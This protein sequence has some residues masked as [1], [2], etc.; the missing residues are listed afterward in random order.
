[1]NER[2]TTTRATALVTSRELKEAFRR[3]SIW[4]ILAVL[5]VGSSAAM[6][7]PDLLDSSDTEYDV[8]IVKAD[9]ADTAGAFEQALR[10]IL[11]AQDARVTFRSVATRA[12]A[13]Q[14][15]DDGTVNAAVVLGDPRTVIARAG[16]DSALVASAQQSLISLER[17]QRLQAQGVDPSALDITPPKLVTVDADQADRRGTAFALSLIVYVVLLMLMSQAASGVAIEK[18]NRISEVLLAVIKPTALLFGKILGVGIVGLVS[19]TVGAIP[20]VTKGAIGG[21]LPPGLGP[22]LAGGAVFFVLGL[23]VYLTIAGSLG[24]LVE[25]Q[26][27]AGSVVAP[28][29]LFLIATYI[30][31]QSTADSDLGP[32]LGIFPLTAPIVMPARIALG[33]A[34]TPEIVASIVVGIATVLVI[35]R[36]G[37]IVYRRGIVQ[38]GRRLHLRDVLRSS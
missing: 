12:R 33:E 17:D 5:F 14:L 22:A 21:D 6:I 36:L 23:A 27:E 24:A 3:R 9:S 18:A 32:L 16:S 13:H 4:I 2:L 25:R 28:L 38:T 10:P 7:V 19:L 34:S 11:R 15:V 1:M 20:V 35:G 8:A 26:E 31:S 37:G 29:S 30:L